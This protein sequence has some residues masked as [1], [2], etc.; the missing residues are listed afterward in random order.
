MTDLSMEEFEM[1]LAAHRKNP[2]PPPK[3]KPL[4]PITPFVL[5]ML[6]MLLAEGQSMAEAREIQTAMDATGVDWGKDWKRL[7]SVGTDTLGLHELNPFP[8]K[9]ALP[10]RLPKIVNGVLVFPPP[11]PLPPPLDADDFSPAVPA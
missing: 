2:K 4:D 5:R 7:R 8:T 6:E 9:W 10:S 3:P 1:R 11:K